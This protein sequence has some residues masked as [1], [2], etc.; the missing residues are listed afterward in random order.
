MIISIILLLPLLSLLTFENVIEIVS[1]VQ[2]YSA[3]NMQVVLTFV[4]WNPFSTARPQSHSFIQHE[5]DEQIV[6]SHVWG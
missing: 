6:T 2:Q 5:C 1:R 4:S 3:R